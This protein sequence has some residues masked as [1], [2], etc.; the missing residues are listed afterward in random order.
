MSMLQ[1]FNYKLKSLNVIAIT[2]LVI[3]TKTI[4]K[5][6][7]LGLFF[8]NSLRYHNPI[9]M[10]KVLFKKFQS[11]IHVGCKFYYILAAFFVE[12]AQ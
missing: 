9:S 5:L 10:E 8:C 12:K 3:L 4:F 7:F 1:S 6:N 2:L 11:E